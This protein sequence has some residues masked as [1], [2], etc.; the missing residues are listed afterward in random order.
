M[1]M[2]ITAKLVWP[3]T[4]WNDAIF[5][6]GSIRISFDTLIQQDTWRFFSYSVNFEAKS[7]FSKM[8]SM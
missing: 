1:Y 5:E 6:L 7:R 3:L 4:L 8:F 2:Y